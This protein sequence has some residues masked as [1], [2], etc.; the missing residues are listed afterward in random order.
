MSG[1]ES[2]D[3]VTGDCQCKVGV[4]GLSCD[5]CMEGSFNFLSSGCAPCGCDAMGSESVGC[6]I[7]GQCSCKVCAS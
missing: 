6:D 4:T 2:C 1:T 7:N 3:Q 5:R